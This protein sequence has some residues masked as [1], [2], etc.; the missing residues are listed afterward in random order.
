MMINVTTNTIKGMYHARCSSRLS[1]ALADAIRSAVIN[2]NLPG[3]RFL[4]SS[5]DIGY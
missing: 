4:V 3:D 5:T 1:N 2:D